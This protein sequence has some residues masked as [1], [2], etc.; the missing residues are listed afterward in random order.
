MTITGQMT[1]MGSQYDS[2]AP[3][4]L[5]D[6]VPAEIPCFHD[7]VQEIALSSF[8]YLESRSKKYELIKTDKITAKKDKFPQ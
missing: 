2:K 3:A 8:Y 7:Y 4:R 5:R 6:T 1:L